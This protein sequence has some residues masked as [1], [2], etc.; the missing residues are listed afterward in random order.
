MRRLKEFLLP[1]VEWFRTL[2]HR[3]SRVERELK[4]E[5][6]HRKNTKFSNRQ[7][8]RYSELYENVPDYDVYCVGSDQVWN[9]NCYTSLNPYML[10]FAP[11]GKRKISYASSFGVSEIPRQAVDQYKKGL[12]ELSYISVREK[13][14]CQIV[15]ELTGKE[16]V[17]VLDPTLLLEKSDWDTVANSSS[18]PK[19]PY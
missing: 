18:C 8:A 5:A 2:A 19:K 3:H 11:S 7:Y 9:P 4:F 14:G 17:L 10:T 1:K 16:G 15:S 6:F 13:T 12:S